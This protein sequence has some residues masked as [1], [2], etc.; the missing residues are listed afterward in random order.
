MF[1]KLIY[2]RNLV[3]QIKNTEKILPHPLKSPIL[4]RIVRDKRV[5]KKTIAQKTS[6]FLKD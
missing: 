3:I 1:Y 4:F 5:F 6:I 2:I